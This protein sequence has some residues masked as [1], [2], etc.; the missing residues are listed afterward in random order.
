MRLSFTLLS[1]FTA[2][3]VALA[4]PLALRRAYIP[5]I[6][7]CPRGP[8]YCAGTNQTAD[9]RYLCGDSRLGP[10][11][12][13]HNPPL[14]TL[15]EN[16]VP[17]GGLCPA[18]WIDQYINKTVPTYLV[19]PPVD[20]FQETTNRLP[21]EGNTTLPVGLLVD[22]FGAETGRYLAP[23]GTPFAQRALYPAAMNTADPAYPYGY[24]LYNV[25]KEFVVLTGPIAPWFGQP[26]QGTQYE[27]NASVA[28][29][30]SGG[31]LARVPYGEE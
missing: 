2:A 22:R 15:F 6:H 10:D 18:D 30:V 29:L 21:L 4:S 7:I 24:H 23:F 9:N 14:N 27:T 26:G 28:A 25:T 8:N 20:G 17:L 13:P 12:L 3:S 5:G 19:F 31:Y 16:Y 1:F 11:A